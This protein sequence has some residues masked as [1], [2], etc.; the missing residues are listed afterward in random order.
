[1][2]VASKTVLAKR[3]EFHNFHQ[4]RGGNK[5]LRLIF[6]RTK[7]P[8]TVIT[9][10][11]LFLGSTW[12]L[13]SDKLVLFMFRDPEVITQVQT[14][15]EWLYE[16][17]SGLLIYVLM[18]T[19]LKH[20]RKKEKA[21]RETEFMQKE[22]LQQHYL[23]LWK[24]DRQGN[25]VFFNKKWKEFTGTDI[26]PN[27]PFAWIDRVHPDHKPY[28]IDKFSQGFLN[29]KPFEA[30]YLLKV[31]NNEFHWVLNTCTPQFDSKGQLDGFMGFYT[32]IEETKQLQE[33]YKESSRRYGYL[34]ANNPN[35]MLVYDTRDLRILEANK[36]AL[37]LYGYNEK[38]FLTMSIVDLRPTSEIPSLMNHIA[39][40]LPEYHRSSGWIH[41][42]KDGSLFDVEITAHSLPIINSRNMRLVVIRDITDQIK[43]FRAAKE[44]D[45]RFR[46]IFD[47]NPL[48]AIICDEN[49]WIIDLNSSA[50]IL[51]NIPSDNTQQL[52]LLD[53]IQNQ[54]S[55][56]D[57]NYKQMLMAG[58][59]L[60]GENTMI[61]HDKT[62]FMASFNAIKFSENGNLRFYFS[63]ADIDEKYR[64]QL[65]LQES[66]R[67][68]ATLVTNFPGM[69][70]RRRN[71]A[72]HTLTFVS[73]G[74]EL[75]TG[76][77]PAELLHNN[78]VSF[79]SLIVEEDK[80]MVAETVLQ[81]LETM[82]RFDLQY[83][84][85][86]RDNQIRWVWEQA[87]GIFDDNNKLNYI[88][89]FIVDITAEKQARYDSEY[90]S[91]FLGLIIDNIPFP[92]FYK[93]KTGRYTGCNKSFCEYLGKPREEI[94]GKTVFD[95]FDPDE[96]KIF[97]TKDM[98]LLVNG[99]AQSYETEI[100]F[101]DGQ[102]MNAVFHKSA[103]TNDDGEPDGIIGVYFDITQRITAEKV[104]KKQ[105][106]EL[107]RVN[108]E[109]ERFSY[110]VSHDLRSPLVTIKGFL[111]LLREDIEEQNYEQADE[112]IMRID[113]ATD[114]MQ[115]LLE[116]LL[117]LSRVGKVVEQNENFSMTEPANEAKE[118]L[119][120][121]ITEKKCDVFIQPDM[122]V[123]NAGK[124][125]I[126]ELYQ[127]LME[128]AVKFS[129]LTT[130]PVIKVYS[131]G[132][133]NVPVFCVGDNGIG[134]NPKYHEKVFGL[135][136]K[137]DS[138]SPGTGL[139]LSLVKR[140]VD[141][142]RGRIWIESD[143]NNNGTIFCFTIKSENP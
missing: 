119:F 68:N 112:D 31:A 128:N 55:G 89:G 28:C 85:R 136:N 38:E 80:A 40:K 4:E 107:G 108:S 45:R 60:S 47:N 9:L 44:G 126:R 10:A 63:F 94:M 113:N 29:K 90:Q 18:A 92:L 129:S 130:H 134:I 143:G 26:E 48:G 115:Q 103:L 122:P 54:V 72:S 95:L 13:F 110:T 114:K 21:L 96:A 66:E 27:R 109:L 116:D 53:F 125:R 137:L 132:E 23:P 139:G 142:H 37:L 86:T 70:Y 65:A 71:D 77:H 14:W 82:Q 3:Q 12:I 138:G 74:V 24:S 91:A 121:L 67:L 88:E 11:Y 81:N 87:R 56:N 69:V 118:L 120:G 135:F 7:K 22:F 62:S 50:H 33:R 51:L 64:I 6:N 75:I 59:P 25:C 131:R 99:G 57:F 32:D 83:R 133:E 41:K 36:A 100:T 2:N 102:K 101:H 1:M 15:K 141:N 39:E 140:I 30:E 124:A 93:D 78:T 84:I 58:I 16:A 8:A 117:K 19:A 17:A 49:F 97:H 34:F 52:N 79:E 61:K 43:A 76:Y 111:G 5:M 35:P 127:N 73:F 46:A 104:I 105:L 42:R 106:E 123:V 20:I 98:D